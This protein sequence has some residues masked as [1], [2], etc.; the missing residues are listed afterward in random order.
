MSVTT[1]LPAVLP[2]ILAVAFAASPLLVPGFGG[3]D[4]NQFPVPQVNPSVQ[5]AG[6]AFS[7]WGLVYLWL[8]AGCAY[9]LWKHSND[10]DWAAMRPALM[11]SMAAGAGWLPVALI[12]PLWATVLIWIMLIPALIALMRSPVSNK[13]WG[14]WPVGLYAGWLSAASSVALGLIAA[15]Y[16]FMDET[17]A[18]W[19]FVGFAIV[20]SF[21]IQWRLGRV[22]TYGIAVIWALIAVAA[23]NA[24]A[25]DSVAVLALAGAA[26]MAW[27]TLRAFR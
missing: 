23:R 1:R 17:T 10:P 14:S 21:A 26:I 4:A 8:I 13:V 9:G 2:L 7:I 15:G 11:V 22:P 18:G 25:L 20:L 6:Y 12:S 16:G 19:V 24:F 3:F 27:P 5:P